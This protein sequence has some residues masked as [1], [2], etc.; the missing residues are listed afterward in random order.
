M[1]AIEEV[2]C[3]V[4]FRGHDGSDIT[5]V[6]HTVTRILM[7]NLENAL[8]GIL[9]SPLNLMQRITCFREISVKFLE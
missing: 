1:S 7:L 2:L 8:S 9:V 6:S 5:I 3:P 4:I